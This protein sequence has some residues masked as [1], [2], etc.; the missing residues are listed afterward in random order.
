MEELYSIYY[1]PKN[2]HRLDRKYKYYELR[3]LKKVEKYLNRQTDREKPLTNQQKE[4]G[5]K[6]KSYWSTPLNLFKRNVRLFQD[7]YF[8]ELFYG[9]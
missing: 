2:G 5:V 3:K 6:L 9:T 4:T 1:N 7:T 8:L